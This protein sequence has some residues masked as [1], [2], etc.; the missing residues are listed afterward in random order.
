MTAQI[1][2]SVEFGAT[3]YS[4]A[5]VAGDGLF[6]PLH[7]GIRPIPL[8]TACHRGF[9]CRYSVRDERL[10][11]VHLEIGIERVTD[12]ARARRRAPTLFGV[13]PVADE[14]RTAATYEG[15]DEPIAF[16]GGL[17]CGHGFVQDLYVHMG[18]QPAWRYETV[19]ELVFR[20]GVLRSATDH[21]AEMLRVRNELAAG[22]R[23]DPDGRGDLRRWIGRTFSLDYERSFLSSE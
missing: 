20:E 2:D 5:G 18:F 15:L 14:A 21:S 9:V 11:L 1:P 10:R 23:A 7:H 16:T 13:A 6:E 19:V 4:I 8:H 22:E 12:D 3:T 17:L